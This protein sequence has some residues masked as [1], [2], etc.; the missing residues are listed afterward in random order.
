MP[1]LTITSF[2]VYSIQCLVHSRSSK[3]THDSSFER[4][5]VGP[6]S[7]AWPQGTKVLSAKWAQEVLSHEGVEK[8]PH[9]LLGRLCTGAAPG[10][11]VLRFLKALSLELP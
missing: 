5:A 8:F 2:P 9:S 10:K 3:N 1:H 4:L 7:I 11:A 6:R